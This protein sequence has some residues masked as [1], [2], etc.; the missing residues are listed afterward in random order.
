MIEFDDLHLIFLEHDA[1]IDTNSLP[2]HLHLWIVALF[3]TYCM[4]VCVCV[5]EYILL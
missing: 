1:K 3:C 2:D 4:C 5:C